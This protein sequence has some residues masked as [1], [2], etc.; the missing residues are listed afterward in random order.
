MYP[1]AVAKPPIVVDDAVPLAG[2]VFASLGEVHALPSGAIDAATL[3]RLGA[4]AL[5]VRSVTTVDA[6]LL[7]ACPEL[8]FVGTATAG[9]DHL[10]LEALAAREVAV[11]DAAGCNSL[12]VAQWVA[13][14]LLTTRPR[15]PE[16]LR[17]VGDAPTVGVVGHGHVGSKVARTL[18]ALGFP[19]L[20]SDPFAPPL[21]PTIAVDFE[22][23]WRRSAIVSFHVP[24]TRGGPHPTA[25]M[26]APVDEGGPPLAGPKLVVNTSRGPV[27]RD[28][29]L[30]RPDVRAAILDVWEGEPEPAAARLRDPKVLLAS[31][32]VAGYSLDAKIDASLAVAR[33]LAARWGAERGAFE[34]GRWL[35]PAGVVEGETSAEILRAVVAL[36]ADDRRVRALAELETGGAGASP[37]ARAFEALRRGYALRR[38]F[39]AWE[40]VGG[41]SRLDTLGF[42]RAKNGADRTVPSEP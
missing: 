34:R 22:T 26:L 11:A 36:E 15:W 21:D 41:D 4:R 9:L 35:G 6:A 2:E 8:E 33:Q 14:A 40:A 24:L 7:D 17:E 27:V 18:R 12:A 19:V 28:A 1:R 38:E 39:G 42:G 3:A 29:A 32:H 30:D 5:V 16:A 20:V 25:A 37:R 10:D 23:L 13:A 31:P